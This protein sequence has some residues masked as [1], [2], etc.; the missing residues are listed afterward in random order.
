MVGAMPAWPQT[1]EAVSLVPSPE[2]KTYGFWTEFDIM[3][4]QTAPFMIFWGYVIDQQ[5]S[6]VLRVAGAPHWQIVVPAAVL[7]SAGNAYFYANKVVKSR[8]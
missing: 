2:A 8:K 3:F 7:V 1:G 6:S 4:W 5:L